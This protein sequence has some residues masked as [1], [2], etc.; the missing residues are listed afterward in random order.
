MPISSCVYHQ[1]KLRQRLLDHFGRVCARC[2]FD[3]ERALQLDHVNGGGKAEIIAKG[4]YGVYRKA[5]QVPAGEYQLLCANCN[6][7]KRV[8]NREERNGGAEKALDINEP[9]LSY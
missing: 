6:W 1:R 8:E 3:D 2:G 9:L 4:T 5:L 7:I